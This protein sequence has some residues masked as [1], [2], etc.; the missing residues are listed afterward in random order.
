MKY[1]KLT[2]AIT[3]CFAFLA[4][5]VLTTGIAS[6]AYDYTTNWYYS[7]NPIAN[8]RAINYQCTDNGCYTLGAELSDSNSG[9]SNSITV[10]YP[11]PAATYGY[12]TYWFSPGYRVMKM[13]YKPTASGSSSADANFVKYSNCQATINSVTSAA[14]VD[15]G[16]QL[17]I[18]VDV[19]SAFTESSGAPFAQPI[20]A[21]LVQDYFSAE[22]DTTILIEDS[23]GI[24]VYTDTVTDYIFAGNSLDVL[25][26]W[27]P[28]FLQAGGYTIT[29]STTVADAKCS[30][31]TDVTSAPNALTVDD[32]PSGDAEVPQFSN[33]ITSPTSPAT[34][35]PGQAYTFNAT[36]TD[37][38]AINS[39]WIEFNDVNY[40]AS[41]NGNV[42]GFSISDLVAGDYSYT[43]FAQ[44][45]SGNINQTV[46]AVY[47]INKATPSLALSFSPSSSVESDDQTTV[48]G[49]GCPS[50]LTCTLYRE[51][52]AVSN[53]DVA[54]LSDGEYDYIY[55][56]TGNANYTSASVSGTL[57]VGEEDDD[58]D[59]TKIVSDN[60]LAS[61]DYIYLDVDDKLKFN[62]CGAPYYIKLTD[63]DE[64][65]EMASF[66]LTPGSN[67]F[68]LEEGENENIDLDSDKQNDLT[69][70]LESI[71]SDDRAKVYI[72]K[73]SNSCPS[74][75][76]ASSATSADIVEKLGS[77]KKESSAFGSAAV[78]LMFGILL[79]SLISIFVFL[80]QR[81]KR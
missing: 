69:F 77:T 50:Q 47:A 61:G 55:S 33:V 65:D 1:R 34:Y 4:F 60:N 48:T 19:E 71:S 37:N 73:T 30:S 68:S 49:S 72:K 75:S 21:D 70:R 27:T 36:W 12:A 24:D 26:Y 5:V 58:D 57:T 59:E 15:E 66:S 18:T 25:F 17:T 43:W 46:S 45:S 54:S 20:D 40:S 2:T 74:T 13:A 14:S 80:G 32:A 29:A 10:S 31:Q 56:T 78:L 62:F 16:Q 76:K 22:T 28:S 42:Y 7:G 41:A 44:D 23:L 64:E 9:A 38:V 81:I 6:A 51:G 52:V 67:T 8:V 11:V 35:A 63:I 79:V 39:V 3:F 53:P